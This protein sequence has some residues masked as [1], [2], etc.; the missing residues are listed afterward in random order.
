MAFRRRKQAEA[1]ATPDSPP[2]PPEQKAT[3]IDEGADLVGRLQFKDGVRIDGHVDGE[4]RA[5]KEV[6]VGEAAAIEANIDANSV[7]VYGTVEGDIRA[8]RKVTLYKSARVT[9]E[10]Q[11]AGI[12]IEEGARFRGCI[13]IGEDELPEE[14][15]PLASAAPEGE[16]E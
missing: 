7:V 12:V 15:P 5:S 8:N 6:V 2:Q 11:T 1:A 3:Y 10:I 9:G 4:I 14:R 13:I 16:G